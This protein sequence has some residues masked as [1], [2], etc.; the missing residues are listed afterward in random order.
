MQLLTMDQV[1]HNNELGVGSAK[2]H[3]RTVGGWVDG[4]LV[5]WMDELTDGWMN[6]WTDGRVN[7]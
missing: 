6:E 2:V 4:W 1:L 3:G 5:F 7:I